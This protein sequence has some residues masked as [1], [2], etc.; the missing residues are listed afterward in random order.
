M[1]YGEY[2]SMLALQ[3]IMPNFVPNPIGWGTYTSNPRIHFF[4]CEFVDLTDDVPEINAFT[5]TLAELHRQALSPNGKY[6][7]AIPTYKGTLPQYNKWTDSWEDFFSQSMRQFMMAEERSQGPDPEMQEL[8]QSILKKVI[9]RL[10]RPLETG[11]RKIMPRLIHGD[12]WAGN[13][14]TSVET[15]LPMVFDAACLYA[16]NESMWR[17][18]NEKGVLLA[19]MSLSGTFSMA[20][21]KTQDLKTIHQSVF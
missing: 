1:V 15:N 11:G 12:I 17:K 13:T 7:F 4:I 10:L 21:Y 3:K 14:S 16:H 8:C 9:P 2:E 18:D 19:Y 20:A 6:G 5:K